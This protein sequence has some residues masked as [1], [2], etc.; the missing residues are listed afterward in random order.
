VG[1]KWALGGRPKDCSRALGLTSRKVFLDTSMR[2]TSL[3]AASYSTSSGVEPGMYLQQRVINTEER[4][5]EYYC[6]NGWTR[7]RVLLNYWT[8]ARRM[9]VASGPGKW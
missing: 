8:R 4:G 2:E 1:A 5:E 6:T 9:D 3:P 7:R